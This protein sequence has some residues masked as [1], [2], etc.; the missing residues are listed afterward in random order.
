MT[1]PAFA[2]TDDL[3]LRIPG[4]IAEEDMERAQAAL[5]D[6]SALIR[7]AANKTWVDDD[8]QLEEDVPGVLLTVC[9]AAARRAITN[10]DGVKA[11]TF[12]QFSQSYANDSGDVYLKRSEKRLVRSAA[13]GGESLSS[14]ELTNDSGVPGATGAGDTIY[15]DV[16]YG[17]DPM[18]WGS[19]WDVPGNP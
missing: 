17:G 16:D 8:E 5:D 13:S 6:A 9:C 2:T 11:E 19:A 18:P 3:A 15:V 4:G 12:D 7:A 10:P 14:V 1:L